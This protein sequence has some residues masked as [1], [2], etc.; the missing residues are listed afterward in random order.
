MELAIFYLEKKQPH[1]YVDNVEDTL[2]RINMGGGILS[3]RWVFGKF[4]PTMWEFRGLSLGHIGV[5]QFVCIYQR[6]Q[7]VVGDP[8]ILVMLVSGLHIDEN[9][10]KEMKQ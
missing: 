8:L 9:Q 2:T 10:P 4:Y 1:S 5:V 3:P 7:I 6:R